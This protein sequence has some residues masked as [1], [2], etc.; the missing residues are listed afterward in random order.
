MIEGIADAKGIAKC[1]PK[2][3]ISAEQE[4]IRQERLDAITK[5]NQ[6]GFYDNMKKDINKD[7]NE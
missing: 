4:R 7:A 2:A 3:F 6:T 5:E 1:Q